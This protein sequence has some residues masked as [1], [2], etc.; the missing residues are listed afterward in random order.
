MRRNSMRNNFVAA[1]LLQPLLCRKGVVKLE[2]KGYRTLVVQIWQ[3]GLP[4]SP[5]AA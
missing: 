1:I 5:E 4:I 2:R 3:V